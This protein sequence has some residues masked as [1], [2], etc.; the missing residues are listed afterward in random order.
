VGNI[1]AAEAAVK[2]FKVVLGESSAGRNL[3]ST[4]VGV[5]SDD[6]KLG[7]RR[8]TGT[9]PGKMGGNAEFAYDMFDTETRR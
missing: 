2:E 4:V 9:F 3:G 1:E 6:C 7:G 8:K 5:R